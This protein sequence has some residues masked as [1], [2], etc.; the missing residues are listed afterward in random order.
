MWDIDEDRRKILV[1]RKMI[2]NLERAIEEAKD[3]VNEL[4]EKAFDEWELEYIARFK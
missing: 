3:Y 2:V 4:E 1:I